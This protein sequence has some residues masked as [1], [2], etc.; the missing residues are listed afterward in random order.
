MGIRTGVLNEIRVNR[1]IAEEI[2][3]ELLQEYGTDD[4]VKI[5]EMMGSCKFANKTLL[6]I[7]TPAEWRLSRSS[8]L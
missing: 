2:R 7:L 1:V 6:P 8:E 4:P 3:Q 5:V